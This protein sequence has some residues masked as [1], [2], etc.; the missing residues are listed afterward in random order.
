MRVGVETGT[1]PYL[2]ALSKCCVEGA[3]ATHTHTHGYDRAMGG[4]G[5]RPAGGFASAAEPRSAVTASM[6]AGGHAGFIAGWRA[7]GG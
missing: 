4:Y 6:S 5:A 7:R 3:G 2:R 1:C